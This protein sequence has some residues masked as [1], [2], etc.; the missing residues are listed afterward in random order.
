MSRVSKPLRRWF[1]GSRR[2]ATLIVLIFRAVGRITP[3]ARTDL[4]AGR[5]AAELGQHRRAIP[6]FLRAVDR[7]RGRVEWLRELARAAEAAEDRPV[8]AWAWLEAASKSDGKQKSRDASMAID[9]VRA[10][11]CFQIALPLLDDLVSRRPRDRR[12]KQALARLL[13]DELRWGGSLSGDLRRPDQLVF[14]ALPIAERGPVPGATED[15]LRSRLVEVLREIVASSP[16][17]PA[18]RVRLADALESIGD[19]LEAAEHLELAVAAAREA[20]ERW[21][22]RR[23]H[24]WEFS[25]ERCRSLAGEARAHDPL[26]GVE[27]RPSAPSPSADP[28]G[29]YTIEVM[30]EGVRFHGWSHRHGIESVEVWFGERLLRRVN[31]GGG[32]V[33]RGFAF[34]LLRPTVAAL[35]SEGSFQ[36]RTPGVGA[37][38]A[39]GKHGEVAVTI[40]HGDGSLDEVLDAGGE[41]DKK[42][43]LSRPSMGLSDLQRQLLELYGQVRDHFEEHLDR[44]LMVLYGTLLGI[45]R[46]GALIPGDDDF[47]VGYLSSASRPAD[48]KV[49]AKGIIRSLL[50][51]GFVVTLNPRGRPF[52]V[53]RPGAAAALH[54]D[55]QAIW[56]QDGH[57]WLHNFS[58]LEAGPEDFVP[59]EAR[60]YEDT[61]L[62]LPRRTEYFLEGHYG[63]NWR[64]P[65]PGFK[66]HVPRE[67]SRLHRLVDD[68]HLSPQEYRLWLQEFSTE[69]LVDVEAPAF[70]ALG[71]QRLY[72]L[73][74]FVG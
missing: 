19:P 64:T 42:G 61:E 48:V 39:F 28:V 12:A 67:S 35:A 47:D 4:W 59:H 37:W 66:Y 22:W 50:A 30:H 5:L 69:G 33:I 18:W 70:V 71:E 40:P 54:L 49:E 72:P 56:F 25:L 62:Y 17:K 21:A 32:Q 16:G 8:A 34:T 58:R 6:C 2:A 73:E 45:H 44:S 41:I 13:A 65:D 31:L 24:H 55:V 43:A 29:V 74:R 46:D 23:L 11:R 51:Q 57:A 20:D 7:R 60:E 68:L 3:G 14:V 27:L 26:F 53:Q 36:L 15:E 9:H 38:S 63:A 52:R 1:R 10:L